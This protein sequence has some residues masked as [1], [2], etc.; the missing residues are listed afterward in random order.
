MSFL[1]SKKPSFEKT[2]SSNDKTNVSCRQKQAAKIFRNFDQNHGL[3]PFKICKFFD[4]S[5]MSFLWSKKPRFKRTTSSNDETNVSCTEKQAQQ[6][7]ATSDQNHW[8]TFFQI[9]RFVDDS[10]MSFLW[11]KKPPFKKKTSSNDKTNVCLTEKQVWKIF[12]TCDGN[13]QVTPFKLSRFFD[14]RKMSF[15]WC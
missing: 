3:T 14:Y 11:S 2:T 4:H 15:L 12:G 9:C 7:F 8:L 10:K 6:I 5:K 13:L 1:W